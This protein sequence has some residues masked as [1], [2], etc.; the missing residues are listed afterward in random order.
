MQYLGYTYPFESIYCSEIPSSLY[1][2]HFYL[3][4]LANLGVLLLCFYLVWGLC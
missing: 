4:N 2:W 1:I 3:L